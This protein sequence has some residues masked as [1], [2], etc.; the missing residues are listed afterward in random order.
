MQIK[1]VVIHKLVKAQHQV[2][3]IELAEHVLGVTDPVLKL[4]SDIHGLYSSKASKGY[5]RFEEDEKAYPSAGYLRDLVAQK[6]SFLDASRGLMAVLKSRADQAPLATGG[7]VLMA[8]LEDPGKG[9]WFIVAMINNVDSAAITEKLEVIKT[10]H[11]D[12]DNLRVAGR[13]NITEWISG[14]V[15]ARYLGFLKQRGE[16]ADYFKL[17]LGCHEILKNL[18][19]TKKLVDVLKGFSRAQELSTE[20]EQ[21][22]FEEAYGFAVACAAKGQPMSLDELANHIWPA[23]PQELQNAFAES[24]IQLSDGFV[25]DRRALNVLIRIRA[26]TKYWTLD[27]QR[28]ALTEGFAKYN[29]TRGELVLMNLPPELKSE[30]EQEVD[31][32]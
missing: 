31:G 5:G 15:Q 4:V 30:L 6:T 13:V 20:D 22:L 32:D 12:L 19:E 18:E 7:Y 16:V 28:H 29:K 23:E 3:T 10:V 26:K 2:A 21:S 27:L 1:S 9:Q 24:G 17:F 8:D 14:D 11:V 25:P